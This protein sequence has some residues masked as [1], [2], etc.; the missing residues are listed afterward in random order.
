MNKIIILLLSVISITCKAQ[1][2]KEEAIEVLSPQIFHVNS[3]TS[4]SG[5]T[6]QVIPIKL[7]PNTIKWYYT[8]SASRDINDVREVQQNYN[9]LSKLS[10][11]I[12]ESGTCAKAINYLGTPP[13]T[14]YCDVYLLSSYDDV[15]KFESKEDIISDGFTYHRPASQENYVSGTKEVTHPSHIRQTQYLGFRNNS[16]SY[17]IDVSLQVV[18]IVSK[19]DEASWT[20]EQKDELYKSLRK[21]LIKSGLRKQLD[22][23]TI[24]TYVGCIMKKLTKKYSLEKLQALAEYEITEV[25]KGLSSECVTELNIKIDEL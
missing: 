18:A 7:P 24:D 25:F 4:L 23:D 14:N 21:E 10:Y 20:T 12:D 15:S 16:M 19:N 6:R 1:E 5:N 13:G 9:L 11:L 22:D 3:V 2:S 17:G 8:F